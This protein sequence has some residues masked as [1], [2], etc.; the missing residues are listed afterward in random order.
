ME[1]DKR[2]TRSQEIIDA[3]TR[4]VVTTH[5]S[6]S[7]HHPA[8]CLDWRFGDRRLGDSSYDRVLTIDLVWIQ[9]AERGLGV[10]SE[11]IRLLLEGERTSCMSIRYIHFHACV[12]AMCRLLRRPHFHEDV[13]GQSVDWWKQVTGREHRYYSRGADERLEDGA[14][15]RQVFPSSD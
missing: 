3:L 9:A 2:F 6:G 8:Y 11:M 5:T 4:S 14:S 10:L 15:F 12:P 1:D 13:V 7:V